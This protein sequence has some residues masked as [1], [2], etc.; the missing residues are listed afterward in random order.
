MTV[1]VDEQPGDAE[2]RLDRSLQARVVVQEAEHP[3]PEGT[4]R[5]GHEAVGQFVGLVDKHALHST[6]VL[7]A[8]THAL[9]PVTSCL[10]V[11]P[12]RL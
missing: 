8:L 4:A 7:A 6:S 2:G 9:G 1:R 10:K 11:F 12:H 3:L 5:L